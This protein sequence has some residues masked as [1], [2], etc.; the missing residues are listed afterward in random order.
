MTDQIQFNDGLAVLTL[1]HNDQDAKKCLTVMLG[2]NVIILDSD[3]S[4]QLLE[5]L[6][7]KRTDIYHASHGLP[8]LPEW[9]SEQEA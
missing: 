5:W 7:Q 2:G 4:M 9:A 8:D 3:K 1:S 6:Y